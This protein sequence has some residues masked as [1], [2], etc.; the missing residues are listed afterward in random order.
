MVE[1]CFPMATQSFELYSRFPIRIVLAEDDLDN[2]K[3][4][5]KGTLYGPIPLQIQ[6]EP[7]QN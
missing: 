4:F 3:V 7:I 6:E 1:T 2:R 5:G